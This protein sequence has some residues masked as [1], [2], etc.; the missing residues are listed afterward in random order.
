MINR[1]ILLGNLGRDPEAR[2]TPNGKVVATL[3][4]ATTSRRK[5]E[6]NWEE[7]TE[8]HSCVAFGKT[9]E[10]AARYLKKGRQVYIEGRIKTEKW[11]DKDGNKR[12]STKIYV[13][14]IRFL[15][16]G[17][18]DRERGPRSESSRDYQKPDDDIPF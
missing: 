18:D 4:V 1:V 9:A 3:S 13:D 6:D 16:R 14:D 15:G 5:V 10:N 8:W 7:E 17:D 12:Y 2:T 11:E